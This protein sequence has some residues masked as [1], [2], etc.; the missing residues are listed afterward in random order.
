[1]VPFMAAQPYTGASGAP[2]RDEGVLGI[3]APGPVLP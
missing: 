2:G 3:E 1:M